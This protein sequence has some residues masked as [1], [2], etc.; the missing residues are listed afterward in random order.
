MTKIN[1]KIDS[2]RPFIRR[3]RYFIYAQIYYFGLSIIL[4]LIRLVKR[5]RRGKPPIR[6]HRLAFAEKCSRQ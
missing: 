6:R 4:L 1:F 2:H 3:R 5:S